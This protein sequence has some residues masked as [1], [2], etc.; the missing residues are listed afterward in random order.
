MSVLGLIASVLLWIA[1]FVLG[2]LLWGTLRA[3][4]F[5]RWRLEHLEATT[6]SRVGRR[7]L[8]RGTPGPGFTLPCVEGKPDSLRGFA[9][10]KEHLVLLQSHCV[11]CHEIVPALNRL[12]QTGD[13]PVVAITTGSLE[14]ARN[15]SGQVQA[16][17]PVLIQEERDLSR[18]YEVF[19]TPFA[20]LIDEHG[21]IVSRG[22]VT[23]PQYLNYVLSG[24]SPET[25]HH[26]TESTGAE[27]GDS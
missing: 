4:A 17:F 10:R 18:R 22:I 9:G 16:R 8:R 11:P 20:F 6:P 14:S 25:P 21:V 2:L 1:V 5:V 15:W 12:H 27:A 13:I 7:G 23:K 24:A 19:A 26:P 3:L